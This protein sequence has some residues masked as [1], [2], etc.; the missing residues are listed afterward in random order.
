MSHLRYMATALACSLIASQGVSGEVGALVTG[1]P[2]QQILK[3]TPAEDLV[4]TKRELTAVPARARHSTEDRRTV[5]A[6]GV[7]T[8]IREAE[9]GPG[10]K[11]PPYG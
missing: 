10:S 6:I 4:F 2:L 7:Y 8:S 5:V 9:S 1:A 3:G 11:R